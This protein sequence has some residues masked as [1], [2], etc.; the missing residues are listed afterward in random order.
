MSRVRMGDRT[1]CPEKGKEFFPSN[2]DHFKGKFIL[3]PAIFR[4][5]SLG[6]R[7]VIH[8]TSSVGKNLR[9]W[10]KTWK[11][12][13]PKKKTWK[14]KQI[15]Q[16]FHVL[17]GPWKPFRL[18]RFLP[19]SPKSCRFYPTKT[20][21]ILGTILTGGSSC[22]SPMGSLWEAPRTNSCD[23]P[24][25]CGFL[26]SFPHFFNSPISQL[27]SIC[28]RYFEDHPRTDARGDR[29][30]GSPPFLARHEVRPFGRGTTLR[31]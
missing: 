3:Q 6:F 22:L 15:F 14:G 5:Y 2:L 31:T 24:R 25:R 13:T 9:V 21:Q 1:K 29:I 11:K 27:S 26:Q 19:S 23:L 10:L 4:G 18:P 16:N 17:G 8:S 20:C 28:S 30:I 12:N 7:G